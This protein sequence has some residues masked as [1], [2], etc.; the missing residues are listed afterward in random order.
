VT[1]FCNNCG[2]VVSDHNSVTA[3]TYLHP[4][5]SVVYRVCRVCGNIQAY[6]KENLNEYEKREK[7]TYGGIPHEQAVVAKSHNLG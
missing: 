4:L 1:A 7:E 3:T 6:V 2:A 5:G